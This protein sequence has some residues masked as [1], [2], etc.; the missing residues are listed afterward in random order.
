MAGEIGM[1][2]RVERGG[3]VALAVGDVFDDR[4]NRMALGILRQPKSGGEA[5]PVGERNAEV[6]DLASFM[7]KRVARGHG[8]PPEGRG[9]NASS[10]AGSGSPEGSPDPLNIRVVAVAPRP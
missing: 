3:S 8:I 6:Q 4:R 1:G 5:R 9:R 2:Q 7:G 10:V